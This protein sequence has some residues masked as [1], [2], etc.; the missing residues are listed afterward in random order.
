M[1]LRKKFID[2]LKNMKESGMGY[3]I[4]NITTKD[5]KRYPNVTITN[6]ENIHHVVSIPVDNIILIE[7]VVR[8]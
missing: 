4:V 6:C 1:K 2:Q 7:P 3:H 5:G 8:N